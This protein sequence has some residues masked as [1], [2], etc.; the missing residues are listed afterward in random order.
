L[1][2]IV[3]ISS[4]VMLDNSHLSQECVEFNNWLMTELV[5][6]VATV[7]GNILFL[8]VRSFSENKIALSV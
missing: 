3:T 2:N 8:F 7:S 5:I 4:H 1:V 6:F